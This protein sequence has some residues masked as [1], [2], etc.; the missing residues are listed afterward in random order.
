MNRCRKRRTCKNRWVISYLGSAQLPQQLDDCC[1]A[2]KNSRCQPRRPRANSEVQWQE[3]WLG[4]CLGSHNFLD[5]KSV[6]NCRMARLRAQSEWVNWCA[7]LSHFSV[8]S[9]CMTL[10]RAYFASRWLW[11]WLNISQASRAITATF[12]S[13]L[14]LC[15]GKTWRYIGGRCGDVGELF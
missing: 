12:R 10:S 6:N 15:C 13:V 5:F 7:M 14:T 4:P 2:L 11:L 9:L 8:A 1:F 3:E